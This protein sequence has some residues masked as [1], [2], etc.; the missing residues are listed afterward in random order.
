[1]L[2]TDIVAIVC[3]V[4]ALMMISGVIGFNYATKLMYN[5]FFMIRKS[6]YSK[7]HQEGIAKDEYF[8]TLCA[9]TAKSE[10][11]FGKKKG[12]TLIKNQEDGDAKN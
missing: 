8:F 12:F 2:F 1:M 9:T 11:H 5:H 4:I 7:A 10:K 6:G 3:L